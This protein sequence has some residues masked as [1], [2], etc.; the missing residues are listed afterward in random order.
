MAVIGVGT[1]SIEPSL[2]S[3]SSL[4]AIRGVT[5]GSPLLLFVI[6]ALILIALAFVVYRQTL[7]P[8]PLFRR[9]LLAGL[10]AFALLLILFLLFEPVM[11]WLDRRDEQAKLLLLVDRSASISLADQGVV[12]DSLVQRFLARPELQRMSA[13]GQLRAYAFGDTVR[14]S[15]LD[16]IKDF[17]PTLVGSDPAGAWLAAVSSAS[18]QDIGAILVVTDGAQNE[19]PA[20]DRVAS[21]SGI[22]IYTVG[23]GD[24]ALRR[25]ALIADLFTNDIAYQGSE[26]PVKVR[27]RGNGVSGQKSRLRITDSR[28]RT[29]ADEVIEFQGSL[30]EKTVEAKFAADQ[31]GEYRITAS[32]DSVADEITIDNNRRSRVIRV[33]DSKFQVVLLAGMPSADVTFARQALSQDTTLDVTALVETRAGIVGG[34][35]NSAETVDAAELFVF[36]N[37]PAGTSNGALWESVSQRIEQDGVP[38]LYLH[39]P[40]VSLT[41]L[42]KIANRLPVE[43]QPQASSERVLL[44][45]A[46]TH[47]AL[48]ARGDL[49]ANWVDLPP[50]LGAIGKVTTKP[51][52]IVVANFVPEV[53]PEL[54]G[55]PAVVFADLNR[56]RTAVITVHETFRWGLGLAKSESGNGFYADLLAR[57]SSWLLAPTDEKRVKITTDRKV[58]SE[59]ETVRFQGQVYG[60]DLT[61]ADD[62]TVLVEIAFGERKERISLIGRG[63]GLYEGD[64]TPWDA[65]DYTFDGFATARGDTL[66]KDNGSLVVE[67]FNLE[68]L[69]SRARF[70][71]LQAVAKNSGGKFVTADRPDSLFANLNLQ[72]RTIE[73]SREIPLW[74]RPMLL[75][76]LIGFL[77]IEWLLRK[78]SGML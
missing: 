15:T 52:A 69:D 3:S 55:G 46:G 6:A 37:Y 22:P 72:T 57:T 48:N 5:F 19:G 49:L 70:D 23:V 26:V 39:G 74:N 60:A 8:V 41:M 53:T 11:S 33:L 50:V 16:S 7:P 38:L 29:L 61:P 28:S 59:G 67:A 9:R 12:R 65:G 30:F 73:N 31:E 10:R 68:W 62:A 64:F 66:G 21:T 36:V 13:A 45:D 35:R 27:V 40:N 71:I 2:I 56:R 18:D 58:Y 17:A 78:R 47:P 76:I 20:P 1:S 24:T 34:G 43:I 63:N 14:E 32:L 25:D 44:R 42:N 75:W 54:S 77:A 4:L 51:S